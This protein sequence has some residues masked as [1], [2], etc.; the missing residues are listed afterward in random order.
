LFS[1]SIG[2]I[3]AIGILVLAV[4]IFMGYVSYSNREIDLRMS[5]LAKQKSNQAT[6]DKAWKVIAQKADITA[7]YK[8]D[9]YEVFIGGM[10]ERYKN[11]SGVVFNWIKEHNPTLDAS[12]YKDLMS[13]VEGM[14]EAF[15]REQKELLDMKAEHDKLRTK[16][17]G[18]TFLA[19]RPEIKVKIVTSA[20]TEDTFET[21]V[22]NDVSLR[23]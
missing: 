6:F 15:N 9:F 12:V 18:S 2:P 21:G 8:D 16:W 13:T 4:I 1:K 23:R 7:N 14:R 11:T 22:E 20:K 5:I 19:T 17:P 3:A 10:N